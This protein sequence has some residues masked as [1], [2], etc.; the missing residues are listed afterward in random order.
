MTPRKDQ[1]RAVALTN[2]RRADDAVRLAE[3]TQGRLQEALEEMET[4]RLR[5]LSAEAF[6]KEVWRQAYRE[7]QP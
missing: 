5:A 6:R 3:I 2:K 1:L 7:V 4:W